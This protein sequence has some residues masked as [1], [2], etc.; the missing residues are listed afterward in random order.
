M[1]P[2]QEQEF[3][4][5]NALAFDLARVNAQKTDTKIPA[6]LCSSP[7]A[8]QEMKDKFVQEFNQMRKNAGGSFCGL[9]FDQQQIEILLKAQRPLETITLKWKNFEKELEA[10]RNDGN[11]TAFFV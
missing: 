1:T 10:A 5:F 8:K 4:P 9:P 11:P 2:E 6:W 7:D 3:T